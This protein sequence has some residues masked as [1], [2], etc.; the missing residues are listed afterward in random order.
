MVSETISL[1]EESP[2]DEAGAAPQLI[3]ALAGET[4]TGALSRHL[5]AG[6]DVVEIG[7]GRSLAATRRAGTVR[8]LE[9]ALP[10][11]AVSSAHLRIN[12]IRGAWIAQDLGAKNPALHNGRPLGEARLLDGDIV[13]VGRTILVFRD[14]VRPVDGPPDATTTE[15]ASH[16]PGLTTLSGPLA[17]AL[18][19]LAGVATTT[20]PL[21]LHG[22]TGAGKEVV[23]RAVHAASKRSGPFVAVNC[24]AIPAQLVESELFGHRRGAFS[25]A[26]ADRAGHVRSSDGGTL[27]LD[28]IA[29]LPLPAQAALLR[30]LQAR[31]V[32]PVGD[33]LPIAV[34]LRVITASHAE[35][36]ARVA[37]GRFRA[38]LLA[39]LD[40][41]TVTLPSLAERREDLGLLIAQLLRKASAT[42]E[43]TALAARAIFAHDWPGN[44]RELEMTLARAVAL[45]DGAALGPA[46]LPPAVLAAIDEQARAPAAVEALSEADVALRARVIAALTEHGGNISATARALGKTRWQIHRWMRAFAIDPVSF[47]DEAS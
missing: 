18:R 42:P 13:E 24:G 35:L 19:T 9:L 16:L 21:V 8:R 41:V 38:D 40:G 7:R 22:A 30:V 3:V 34:D 37:D 31:E 45:A 14:A 32:V 46:Q 25:G 33:S 28:E 4:I 39:R 1:V 44:V 2:A 47:R 29:D 5:L 27:F 12:V 11:R 15:L 17:S 20:L 36:R 26:L 43:L 6:V 23:A 10:D